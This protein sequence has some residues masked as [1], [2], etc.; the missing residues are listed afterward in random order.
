M[1][2]TIQKI[3]PDADGVRQME[4]LRAFLAT[5]WWDVLAECGDQVEEALPPAPPLPV[6]SMLSTAPPPVG[7]LDRC[8][9]CSG[10]GRVAGAVECGLCFGSRTVIAGHRHPG[11]CC[12]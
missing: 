11:R 7:Y 10:V 5:R 9:H 3:I 6:P 1:I 2:L 12:E 4:E 8:P